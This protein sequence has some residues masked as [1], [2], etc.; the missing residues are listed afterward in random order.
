MIMITDEQHKQIFDLVT[1]NLKTGI[2]GQ[3]YL[4]TSIHK[5]ISVIIG[6]NYNMLSKFQKMIFRLDAISGI[7]RDWQYYKNV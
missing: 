5:K 3:H 2:S 7:M 1:H 6:G 4:P